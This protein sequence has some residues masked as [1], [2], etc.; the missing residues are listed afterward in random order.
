MGVESLL[1][2]F[3]LDGG[4]DLGRRF[5][6]AGANTY[7]TA[8]HHVW[9]LPYGRNTDRADYGLVLGEGRGTCSTKHAL[10]AALA[11]EHDRTVELALG[12]YEMNGEN[13]PGVGDALCRHGLDR[14]PEAHCY[15]IH[16]GRRVDLTR[17][18]APGETIT[19]FLHEERIEPHQ[20]GR[21]KVALHREFV[22]RWAEER[23]L[24]PERVWQAR[25]D[26][27][28]SLVEQGHQ[29][30]RGSDPVRDAGFV[31]EG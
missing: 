22:R 1:P 21:H 13:T 11:A 6:A 17:Q 3:P 9:S 27:I 31:R 2:D 7:R 8:A 23:G 19:T 10:L 30:G 29:A 24:D 26:C 14:V 16:G 25:E 15:L 28:A 4:G 12:I 18:G 20:I 5:V